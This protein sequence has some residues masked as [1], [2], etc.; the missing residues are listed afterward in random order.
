MKVLFVSGSVSEISDQ[1]TARGHDVVQ[2]VQAYD[3]QSHLSADYYP[4]VLIDTLDQEESAL[5]LCRAIRELETLKYTYILL[6]TTVDEPE[7]R[8][9]YLEAGG[10]DFL[11]QPFAASDL[12]AKLRVASR[13]LE[14]QSHALTD[15]QYNFGDAGANRM[16]PLG[17]ILVSLGIID[18][19]TLRAGL[20]EQAQTGERLG[21]ILQSKNYVTEED[22]TR[23]RSIQLDVTYCNVIDEPTDAYLLS[24]IP[25]ETARKYQLLVLPPVKSVKGGLE[26]IRIAMANPGDIEAIDQLQHRLKARIEPLLAS[27]SGIRAAIEKAYRY[28]EDSEEHHSLKGHS[29]VVVHESE[30]ELNFE[31][32]VDI[33]EEM[34]RSDEAPIVA[35]VNSLLSDAVRRRAS[36]IHIEP[37]KRDFQILYRMDGQLQVVR[38]APKQHFA[39]TTSRIKIM[40]ELDIAERRLPQDGRIS[41]RVEDRPVDLRISTLPTQFGERIVLRILDRSTSTL[42]LDRVG[43]SAQENLLLRELLQQPHGLILVTGPTGSGKTTTLYSALNAVKQMA[44]ERGAGRRNIITCEDPIEYELEGISQSAVNEKAGL[45]FAKQLRAILR[46]DPDVVLVG[47]IRDAET[48]EIALRASL[49]GHLV[50]SS[51]H[52]NEAA[53]AVSRLTDIGLPPYLTASALSGV[54]AQRLARRLCQACRVKY[55]PADHVLSHISPYTKATEFY[56][57]AGCVDCDGTGTKGRTSVHEIMIVDQTIRRMITD[58]SDTNSVR[59]AAIAAGMKTLIQVGLEKAAQ[60][61]VSLDEILY[62]VGLPEVE[63]PALAPQLRV[64]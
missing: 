2:V 16:E 47:E 9:A 55:L 40:A 46:Q 33:A 41:V 13:I 37:R 23:A 10:D 60:G 17:S 45:T 56:K 14:I 21:E 6:A 49:T 20:A 24:Q 59:R 42:D 3:I 15:K 30:E 61:E 39:A 48:A 52:C 5:I 7:Y 22:I 58:N 1:L 25:Y 27:A 32:S 12:D 64:A 63:T 62:R 43:L 28:A 18:P 36:D 31:E 4:L 29:D 26:R 54:V 34:K 8:R 57:P 19:D 50:L 44:T 53:G 38:T 51:L 11:L 35:F